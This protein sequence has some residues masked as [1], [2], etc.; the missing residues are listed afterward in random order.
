MRPTIFF[1]SVIVVASTVQCVSFNSLVMFFKH[2]L[3]SLNTNCHSERGTFN[4]TYLHLFSSSLLAIVHIQGNISST[5]LHL[6]CH[7]PV[8]S[9]TEI[10]V[11]C[12]K[13]TIF[14]C[15]CVFIE[16][17]YLSASST[18]FFIFS[19]QLCQFSPSI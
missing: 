4:R 9:L 2:F 5:F 19:K 8:N 1:R 12:F 6:F 7:Y 16:C 17:S 11:S 14:L 15:V 3:S 10:A 18:C 13:N